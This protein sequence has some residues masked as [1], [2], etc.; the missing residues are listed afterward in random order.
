MFDYWEIYIYVNNVIYTHTYI[1]F[2]FFFVYFILLNLSLQIKMAMKFKNLI[3]ILFFLYFCP[4]MTFNFIQFKCFLIIQFIVC[5]IFLSFCAVFICPPRSFES[6]KIPFWL[7]QS[8]RFPLELP[9]FPPF[10]LQF[11]LSFLCFLFFLFFCCRISCCASSENQ[12]LGK[13][14]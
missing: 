14:W 11:P 4:V 2:A 8:S 13:P 3:F 10:C 6:I 1:V 12:T 7:K 9:F 5:R